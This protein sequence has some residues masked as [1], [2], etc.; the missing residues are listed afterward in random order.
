[1]F[2]RLFVIVAL[3]L[4]VPAGA[5]A[6][7]KLGVIILHGKQGTPTGNQ[8][9]SVIASNLQAAGHKV[10]QPAAPWGRGA[11]ET[12]NVTVEEALAQL[13]GYAG[14]LRAQGANRIVVIGHSLGACVA[15]AYAVE[16]GNLAGV[17]MLAPGHNPAG[18]YRGND[19]A[20]RD[21]DHARA[22]VE[23]GKGNETMSGSD[24][25]Q[26]SN[27][28]MSVRAAV[29]WSW[30]NPAGLASMPYEAPRLPASTPILMVVG[31]GD[32][33]SGRAE[34]LIFKPAAKNPYSRYVTNGAS[35]FETPM[36][37]AKVTTDWVLGLPR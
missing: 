5:L 23:Q 33:M 1:M 11:W 34:G 36:A 4:A 25:N 35:H 27:I 17:V 37:A 30:Q 29:Y 31:S 9:L 19:K 24:A 16:R 21:I 28:T 3:C 2:R 15:L 22:L 12:I 8:G 18:R 20:R 10:V 7:D 6:Q 32:P 14:Q 26:G 13:D